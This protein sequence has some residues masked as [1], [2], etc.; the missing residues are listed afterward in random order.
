MTG[1]VHGLTRI[2]ARL[3]VLA[4]CL[5]ASGCGVDRH[6]LAAPTRYNDPTLVPVEISP[7]FNADFE[8][9]EG[10]RPVQWAPRK[11][12]ERMVSAVQEGAYSGKNALRID[13]GPE[14]YFVSQTASIDPSLVAGKVLTVTAMVKTEGAP[15][16]TVGLSLDGFYQFYSS[17]APSNGRWNK[18]EVSCLVPAWWPGP[19]ITLTLNTGNTPAG[20]VLFDDVRV[21]VK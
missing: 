6:T 19:T 8:S 9:V 1:R 4:A 3:S 13:Q 14:W 16:A 20:P 21:Y 5:L 11:D 15:L 17:R 18:V 12:R 2:V 7:F 10:G